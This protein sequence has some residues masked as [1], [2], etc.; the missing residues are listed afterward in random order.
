[1]DLLK[2]LQI[3]HKDHILEEQTIYVADNLGVV[4]LSTPNSYHKGEKSFGIRRFIYFT[5]N[6]DYLVWPCSSDWN[7]PLN[8]SQGIAYQNMSNRFFAILFKKFIKIKNYL[9]IKYSK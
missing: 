6:T 9:K 5:F 2:F 3:P 7:I 1:M 4:V 8:F